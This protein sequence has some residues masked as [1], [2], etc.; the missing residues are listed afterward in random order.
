MEAKQKS[1]NEFKWTRKRSQQ[2]HTLL[3]E[4]FY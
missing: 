3:F 2:P 4:M 1:Q